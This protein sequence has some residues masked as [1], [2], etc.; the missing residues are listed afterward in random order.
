MSEG[1][2]ELP[3]SPPIL[4][5]AARLAGAVTEWLEARNGVTEWVASKPANDEQDA[6][7]AERVRSRAAAAEKAT[8]AALGD[9]ILA[10]GAVR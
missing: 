9:Y 5:Q 7:M 1:I 4:E 6:V 3:L 10:G 8:R 2:E